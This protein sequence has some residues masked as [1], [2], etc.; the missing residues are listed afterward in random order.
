MG[1]I[2]T[3]S[4]AK[5][6]RALK[7]LRK[8]AQSVYAEKLPP[9]SLR[10]VRHSHALTNLRQVK[11]IDRRPWENRVADILAVL[12][13]QR[14]GKANAL[15]SAIDKANQ[16]VLSVSKQR[17]DLETHSEELTA[18]NEEMRAA[19]EEMRAT[20]EE[21]RAANEELRAVSEELE[22]MH[23]DV[24]LFA[25]L[26]LNKI[27]L[28][29]DDIT[30]GIGEILARTAGSKNGGM[31]EETIAR[32]TDFSDTTSAVSAVMTGM[33]QYWQVELDGK[34]FETTDCEKLLLQIQLDFQNLLQT[35]NATL[36]HDPFPEVEV[37]PRQFDTLLKIL[38]ENAVLFN[39]ADDPEIHISVS[40]VQDAEIE[41]PEPKIENG[42]LFCVSDNGPGI[43][44]SG[45]VKIFNIFETLGHE[46]AGMG[47][48]LAIA[49]RIV[50]RHGG[51]IWVVSEASMGSSFYFTLP[52]YDLS[53]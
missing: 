45:H 39:D 21:M 10:N 36:T 31:D 27:T 17:A 51:H 49:W 28:P 43:T 38:I 26:A 1:D 7:I 23:T 11:R 48:G 33:I 15:H 13:E 30:R 35:T 19:N 3:P 29:L 37:D 22:R 47:M 52:V 8:T 18:A 14:Y 6:S 32:L 34:T 50:K 20:N 16:A 44:E 53:E 24:E 5:G 40:D 42:W 46:K 2:R 9:R 4:S 25:P 12:E 41:I